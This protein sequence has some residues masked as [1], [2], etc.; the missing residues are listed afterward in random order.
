MKLRLDN[1]NQ[2]NSRSGHARAGFSLLEII[3]VTALMVVIATL[4]LPAM[5]RFFVSQ[6]LD[7]AAE[8]VRTEMGRARVSAIRSGEIYAFMFRPGMTSFAVVPFNNS[9]QEANF[10][11]EEQAGGI[12][13]R[14]SEF[15]FDIERLPQGTIFLQADAAE[16]GRSAQAVEDSNVNT[17]QMIP[18][19]FYPDGSSQDAVMILRNEKQEEVKIT[20]RGLTALVTIQPFVR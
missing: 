4:T 12:D 19:L 20:L 14:V 3:L 18:I 16:D 1:T 11:I 15:S 6:K 2:Q 17:S 5:T 7:K 13:N 10:I 9:F 8:R